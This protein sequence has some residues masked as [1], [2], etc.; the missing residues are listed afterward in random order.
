MRLKILSD[1]V[2]LSST[3]NTTVNTS[4]LVRLVNQHATTSHVIT[5]GNGAGTNTG[6]VTILPTT[7]LILEKDRTETIQVDA[8]SDVKV[9][10]IAYNH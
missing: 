4:A 1:E 10:A 3:S 5:I 8:G 9:V 7:E 6:N 2:T